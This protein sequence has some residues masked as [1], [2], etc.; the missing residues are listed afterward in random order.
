MTPPCP[1][2]KAARALYLFCQPGLS[3]VL[4]LLLRCKQVLVSSRTSY[5]FYNSTWVPAN[6]DFSYYKTFGSLRKSP[7]CLVCCPRSLSLSASLIFHFITGPV[8]GNPFSPYSQSWWSTLWKYTRIPPSLMIDPDEI[9][10][11]LGG[12]SAANLIQA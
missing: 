5:V 6:G 1:T 2:L 3:Y 11:A 10:D 7:C 12:T 9:K 8:A 4:S